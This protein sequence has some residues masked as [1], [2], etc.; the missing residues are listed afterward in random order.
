[1]QNY[2]PTFALAPM[3]GLIPT[4]LVTGIPSIEKGSEETKQS[5]NWDMFGKPT[6][7]GQILINGETGRVDVIEVE[8]CLYGAVMS[9]GVVEV[10]E[11]FGDLGL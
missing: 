1:M 7:L 6:K 11:C 10:G 5:K 9:C 3:A 4:I 8:A 2:I